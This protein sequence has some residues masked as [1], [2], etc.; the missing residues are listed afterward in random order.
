MSPVILIFTWKLP[1][2]IRRTF[3]H[4]TFLSAGKEKKR[5]KTKLN[6]CKGKT[7]RKDSS[8]D[9]NHILH[10][11]VHYF[12]NKSGKFC[13]WTKRLVLQKKFYFSY[14]NKNWR[15]H[16]WNNNYWILPDCKT[17]W[18]HSRVGK[19]LCV[20]KIPPP[21]TTAKVLVKKTKN[22]DYWKTQA[23]KQ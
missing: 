7:W 22:I 20:S 13:A 2:H 14:S 18:R 10:V 3:S 9:P 23:L 19:V 11:R 16:M 17:Q 15:F 4:F 1:T 5:R 8:T 6:Y 21:I 12:F